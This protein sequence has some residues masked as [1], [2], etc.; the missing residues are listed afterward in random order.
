MGIYLNINNLHLCNEIF[1]TKHLQ[2]KTFLRNKNKLF[3]KF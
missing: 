1:N 3:L 2:L